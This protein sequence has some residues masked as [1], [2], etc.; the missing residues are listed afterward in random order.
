MEWNDY[1]KDDLEQLRR[2]LQDL[3][4]ERAIT[5]TMYRYLKACDIAKDADLISSYFADD[6]V[7]EGKGNFAEFGVTR[8]REAIRAMF[9]DNPQILPFTA[10]FV[11]N[12][13]VV[14]S[15][16]RRSAWGEWHCLEAATLR[17]ERAQVWIAARY[18]NDFAK[19][20][21][22]WK[23]S[24]IRYEDTFVCTYEGGWLKER[25]VSPLTLRKQV[26]L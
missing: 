24:H 2:D 11:A 15:L 18:D 16:D 8:G 1:L 22:D 20:G 14:L 6:A 3:R 25:Y 21:D 26:D 7:W 10:H 12:P 13:I 4:D 9:L 19:V 23:I 5:H 17:D